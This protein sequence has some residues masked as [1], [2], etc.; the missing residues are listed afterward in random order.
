MQRPVG[1]FPPPG[2]TMFLSYHSTPDGVDTLELA[3]L[4]RNYVSCA[5]SVATPNYKK[6]E[7]LYLS[8]EL[9]CIVDTLEETLELAKLMRN[10]GRNYVLKLGSLGETKFHAS[11]FFL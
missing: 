11:H 6:G 8:G 10:S 1:M 3:K 2:E 4:M 5:S 9:R 7:T